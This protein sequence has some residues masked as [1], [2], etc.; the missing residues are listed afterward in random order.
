LCAYVGELEL[1]QPLKGILKKSVI[2]LFFFTAYD[3]DNSNEMMKK[4]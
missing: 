2:Y 1:E 3:D 4:N